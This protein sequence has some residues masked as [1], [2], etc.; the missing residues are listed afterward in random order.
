MPFHDTCPEFTMQ[1]SCRPLIPQHATVQGPQVCYVGICAHPAL[2]LNAC[3]P[4]GAPYHVLCHSQQRFPLV[5]RQYIT[6][7]TPR[8]CTHA[9]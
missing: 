8:A 1:H 3:E 4:R 6:Q 9:M 2:A 7:A 5:R